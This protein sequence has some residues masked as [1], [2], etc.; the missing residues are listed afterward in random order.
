MEMF[1]LHTVI[2]LV[3]KNGVVKRTDN[4]LFNKL[5]QRKPLNWSW[6]LILVIFLFLFSETRN[7]TTFNKTFCFILPSTLANILKGFAL[8]R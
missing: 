6:Q 3:H 2:R 8:A 1:Y 7:T 5:K 4:L